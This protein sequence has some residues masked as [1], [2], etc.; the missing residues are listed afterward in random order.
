MAKDHD[1]MNVKSLTLPEHRPMA[2]D[3][4]AIEAARHSPARIRPHDVCSRTSTN[5]G[6]PKN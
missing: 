5:R 1:T 4:V 6:M 2:L 3:E